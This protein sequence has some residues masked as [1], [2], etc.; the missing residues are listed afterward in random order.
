[1]EIIDFKREYIEEAS[2]LAMANYNEERTKVTC[3]PEVSRIPG[4][5]SFADNGLGVAAFENRKMTGFLCCCSP[6]EHAFHTEAVGTFSPVHAH[7][8]VKENRAFLY[9]R[10]YQKAA[11]K[12]VE[13][14][15]VSHAVSLYAH[16]REG[17]EA[18]FT[19]GFG[20]RCVDAIRPME[21]LS[22]TAPLPLTLSSGIRYEEL[23]KEHQYKIRDLRRM[24]IEHMGKAPASCINRRKR[25]ISLLYGPKAEIHAY[26]QFYPEAP[27]SPAWNSQLP[28]KP[29]CRKPAASAIYAALTACRSTAEKVFTRGS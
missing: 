4:L 26:L 23:G 29:S 3:L 7:G 9:R 25:L 12:W 1:M 17:L 11:E 8:A 5:Q 14:K 19:C 15:I 10:M 6:F 16:D 22:F 20:L 13:H 2:L 18:F 27:P 21:P 28:R 24:L